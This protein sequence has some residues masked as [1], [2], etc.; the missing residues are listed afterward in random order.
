MIESHDDQDF[1]RQLEIFFET[2]FERLSRLRR[3][4]DR[5]ESILFANALEKMNDISN[6]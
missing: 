5:R 6:F 2:F 3:R 4:V 1:N